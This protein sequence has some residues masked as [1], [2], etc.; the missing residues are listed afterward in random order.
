MSEIGLGKYVVFESDS[1]SSRFGGHEH[2]DITECVMRYEP[3]RVIT[4]SKPKP[5]TS[6]SDCIL[7]FMKSEKVSFD[8][9]W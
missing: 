4:E 9:R 2:P 6:N 1:L 7:N 5:S 8:D 3:R